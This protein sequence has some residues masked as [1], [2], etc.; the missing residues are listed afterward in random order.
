MKPKLRESK[1]L[2]LLVFVALR[3]AIIF[4]MFRQLFRQNY[5]DVLLCFLSLAVMSFPALLHIK[6]RLRLPSGL[7]IAVAAFVFAAEILG[8]ISNFYGQFPFWDTMLHTINGFLAAAIGFNVIDLLNSHVKGVNLTPLFVALVSFCFSMTVGVLWEFFEF[9]GD[10]LARL[11]MQK[12][13]IVQS[14]S[15]V[16]LDPE[17]DN[18]TITIDG[19][20]YT[21]LYDQEGTELAVIKGG[22]LDIGII[23]TM[24]DLI[25]NMVGALVF[26]F[27]GYLYIYRRD[28]YYFAGSFLIIQESKET[29]NN[30]SET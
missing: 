14:I 24:K 29:T 28:K 5:Q 2:T 27:L 13:W 22:Y 15:T 4:C 23:D 16:T 10:R 25:V 18:N 30:F 8:E 1:R 17:Q 9:G 11:D 6:L 26:S 21:V 7:E 3:I 12:D 19:I 20:A